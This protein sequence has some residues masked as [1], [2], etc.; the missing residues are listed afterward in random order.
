MGRYY[1]GDIEGKFWFG[2]QSSDDADFFGR[3]GIEPDYLYYYFSK[4][5]LESVKSGI[6][7]CKEAL[8]GNK[9]KI[10]KF[11]KNNNGYN[12]D[13]LIKAGIEPKLIEWYARLELGEKIY[14]CIKKNG[15]CE[16]DAER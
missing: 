3:E 12:D 8:K 5:D 7:K 15:S 10:D 16:F 2:V 6:R 4:D 13:M 14:K 11:F 1:S 9:R